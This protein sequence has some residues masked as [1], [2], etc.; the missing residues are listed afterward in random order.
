MSLTDKPTNS[1]GKNA[2][3]SSNEFSNVH[4]RH[5]DGNAD[6]R[7]YLKRVNGVEIALISSR[8]VGDRVECRCGARRWLRL[9]EIAS[10]T[11][12]CTEQIV[13]SLCGKPREVEAGV[14][15]PVVDVTVPLWP[16]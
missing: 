12:D 13:C 2:A 16:V 8:I 14:L 11:L 9:V 5:S 15:V 7:V 6:F 3:N 10:Q 4:Y 1:S